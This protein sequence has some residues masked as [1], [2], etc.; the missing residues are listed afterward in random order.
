[1]QYLEGAQG[2]VPAKGS[3]GIGAEFGVAH[4]VYDLDSGD[5]S[6]GADHLSDGDHGTDV[7]SG[8]AGSF[9]FFGER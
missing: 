7:S 4:G 5:Y 6:D 3:F 9:E 2:D 1:L 8:N